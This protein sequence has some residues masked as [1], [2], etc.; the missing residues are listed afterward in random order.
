MFI[1]ITAEYS[2]YA[3]Y[4]EIHSILSINEDNIKKIL[5]HSW[6]RLSVYRKCYNFSY[7]YINVLYIKI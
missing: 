7:N 2:K 3:K 6:S 5:K 1:D 4:D